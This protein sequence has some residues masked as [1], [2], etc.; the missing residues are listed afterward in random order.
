M[1]TTASTAGTLDDAYDSSIIADFLPQRPNRD[2]DEPLSPQE[3]LFFCHHWDGTEEHCRLLAGVFHV[4]EYQVRAWASFYHLKPL[5]PKLRPLPELPAIAAES[6]A[7]RMSQRSDQPQPQS[8]PQPQPARQPDTQ[9][10]PTVTKTCVTCGR[11]LSV[12]LFRHAPRSSDGYTKDCLTC[13]RHHAIGSHTPPV[14]ASV[15]AS[16]PVAVPVA[17]PAPAPVAIRDDDEIDDAPDDIWSAPST[18]ELPAVTVVEH[19][20]IRTPAAVVSAPAVPTDDWLER[21]A[22]DPRLHTMLMLMRNLPASMRWSR[23]TRDAW[24]NAMQALA[25]LFIHVER[26]AENEE[27]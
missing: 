27:G 21:A 2:P 1:T 25:D 19:A 23:Q 15:P 9:R 12:A 16:V 7:P 20:A 26:N 17:I 22:S 11:N 14:T 4:R 10:I 3:E 13:S 5:A 24:L 6:R 8:Q 18:V